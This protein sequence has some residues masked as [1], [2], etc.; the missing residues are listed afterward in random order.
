LLKIEFLSI[1]THNYIGGLEEGSDS[2]GEE[3]YIDRGG[4]NTFL[5]LN[6]LKICEKICC[7]I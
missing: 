7:E 6:E 2:F 5:E 4:V 1:E 3:S